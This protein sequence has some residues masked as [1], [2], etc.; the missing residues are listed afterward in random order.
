[1]L[2]KLDRL[3]RDY[4]RPDSFPLAVKLWKKEDSVP[5]RIKSPT[6]LGFDSAIC[7]TFGISRRYGWSMLLKKE[8]ISC[9][10]ALEAFGFKPIDDFYK[11]GNLTA[12]MYTKDNSTGK[13]TESAVP[14]L[15]FGKY[16][17]LIVAPLSRAD[18]V[19]DVV[20]IYCNPAQLMRLVAA[21]LY[22]EGGRLSSSF[23][24]RIDCA[25]EIISTVS[26]KRCKVVL[27]CYGDRVFGGTQDSEM[28]FSI[29]KEK[30]EEII[31]GLEGTQRG[32]VRYPIPQFLRFSAKYPP[33][34]EKLRS[35]LTEQMQ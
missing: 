18:F 32:G 33:N 27:P 10:L 1:M 34:Y 16:D 21:A 8:E 13:K 9:P 22:N 7:Q 30:I 15:K 17:G 26:E 12:G 31:E 11:N 4:V 35:I 5:D 25:D 24:S 3:I 19:P 29:P 14:K 28:A 23:A 20:V 2:E 6:E